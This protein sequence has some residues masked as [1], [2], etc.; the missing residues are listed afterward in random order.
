MSF[1]NSKDLTF[2]LKMRDRMSAGLKKSQQGFKSVG[3]EIRQAAKDAAFLSQTVMGVRF[4]LDAA[5]QSA[6][7]FT[8]TMALRGAT[9]G[10]TALA[11]AAQLMTTTLAGT[12]ILGVIKL[13]SAVG[14]LPKFM[15]NAAKAADVFSGK[16]EVIGK[17]LERLQVSKNP[18]LKFVGWTAAPIAQLGTMNLLLGKLRPLAETELKLFQKP[19]VIGP[20]ITQ[21]E[22]F[23]AKLSGD[24]MT[25]VDKASGGLITLYNRLD[26]LKKGFEAVTG[27]MG[28][29]IFG[30]TTL[31]AT[32]KGLGDLREFDKEFQNAFTVGG[33]NMDFASGI[34]KQLADIALESGRRMPEVAAAF[35]IISGAGYEGEQALDILRKSAQGAAAGL[36]EISDVASFLMPVMKLYTDEVGDAE[37]ASDKLLR[38]VQEGMGESKD[39][40]RNF[41]QV[42][43]IARQAGVSFDELISAT[44]TLTLSGMNA[45]EAVTAMRQAITDAIG[46]SRQGLAILAKYGMTLEDMQRQVRDEGIVAT[47]VAMEKKLSML[48][49]QRLF[50]QVQGRQGMLQLGNDLAEELAVTTKA[51]AEDSAGAMADAFETLQGSSFFAM[52]RILTGINNL[53]I[54]L[55]SFIAPSVNS[56][57]NFMADNYD[58]VRDAIKQVFVSLTGLFFLSKLGPM[59]ADS[60]I[61]G[62]KLFGR[63]ATA[64]LDG[65]TIAANFMFNN[66]FRNVGDLIARVD[67]A[68]VASFKALASMFRQG[69]FFTNLRRVA[70]TALTGIQV[71]AVN[72]GRFIVL[73][74]TN[75]M[76]AARIA[77]QALAGV[78]PAVARGIAAVGAAIKTAMGVALRTLGGILGFVIGMLLE[79]VLYI[80]MFGDQMEWTFS[81]VGGETVAWSDVMWGTFDWLGSQISV[82]VGFV[83]TKFQEWSDWLGPLI[84]GIVWLFMEMAKHFIN[85][86]TSM[87]NFIQFLVT[88]F[89]SLLGVVGDVVMS[90]ID[91]VMELVDVVTNLLGGIGKA[92][93]SVFKGDFDAAGKAMADGVAQAF[94]PD[95]LTAR[96]ASI[97]N[98]GSEIGAAWSKAFNDSAHTTAMAAAGSWDSMVLARKAG[99]LARDKVGPDANG[100]GVVPGLPPPDD[101]GTGGPSKAQK[102]FDA[103]LLGLQTGIEETYRLVEANELW[104][105]SADAGTDNILKAATGYKGL[106]EDASHIARVEEIRNK[107]ADDLMANGE[108]QQYLSE[109]ALSMAVEQVGAEQK[110]VALGQLAYEQARRRTEIESKQVSGPGERAAALAALDKEFAGRRAAVNAQA[111]QITTTEQLARVETVRAGISGSIAGTERATEIIRGRVLG[112]ARIQAAVEWKQRRDS[113]LKLL[114]FTLMREEAERI[115]K[116]QQDPN[117]SPADREAEIAAIQREIEVRKERVKLNGFELLALKLSTAAEQKHRAVSDT[118]QKTRDTRQEIAV[119]R[120]L[121]GVRYESAIQYAVET[122]RIEATA[123]ARKKHGDAMGEEAQAYIASQMEMARTKV[124]SDNKLPTFNEGVKKAMEDYAKQTADVGTAMGN[125]MVDAI[126]GVSDAFAAFFMDQEFEWDQFATGIIKQIVRIIAQILVMK[127]IEAG[128]NLL[129]PGSGTAFTA[130]AAALNADGNVYGSAQK[131]AKGSAFAN[132]IVA[133]PTLFAFK[134]GGVPKMGMMGEA[135]PE[136]IIPLTRGRDGKLGVASSGG[137]GG[138]VVT[139]D[140]RSNITINMT[141]NSDPAAAR[142]QSRDAAEMIKKVL[143]A[144]NNE[145]EI[146]VQRAKARLNYG[147]RS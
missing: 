48:D 44:S 136:A 137:G 140:A 33:A 73:G 68:V 32:M 107:L 131:F 30:L 24:L 95:R 118:I 45:S 14:L 98:H 35:T 5:T 49:F 92:I 54:E 16:F 123:E 139:V 20:L 7:K 65:V 88:A 31:F 75:P 111:A 27:P 126:N 89:N 79:F 50:D 114:S 82:W 146:K 134:N 15:G 56:A 109:A 122:A 63:V 1:A 34:K 12:N 39:F 10:L 105:A 130:A 145:M 121:M 103:V 94:N 120:D 80:V 55:G 77:A 46:P 96:F 147:G 132:S 4:N 138:Q 91:L 144:R 47:V 108:G 19:M 58:L 22:A 21:L 51:V 3:A 66:L 25:G 9:T 142:K 102:D 60:L 127:A 38:A 69:T 117:L 141:E 90:V 124:E 57:L 85:V 42:F 61:G 112:Q 100:D 41:G 143:D 23:T 72:T 106:F 128:M 115:A 133:S 78:L 119:M 52:E 125:T 26:S 83:M 37:V 18:F 101:D 53:F 113:E 70:V 129:V 99:R 2:V 64:A 97:K 8:Q 17:F 71:A 104:A 62:F 29:T 74:L 28:Q 6:L 116:V 59:L 84:D 13:G 135:G 36:G 11:S 93:D 87:G 76:L 86:V 110:K 67:D 43:G 81:K 40:A